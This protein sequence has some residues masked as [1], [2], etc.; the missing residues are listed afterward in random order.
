MQYA[1]PGVMEYEVAAKIEEIALAANGRLSYPTILT[2]NGQ[3][4]HNHYH[5][6][7]IEEGQMILM[8]AGGENNMHYAG[9]LTR[10]FPVDKTFTSK[11]K[12]VYNIVLDALD[13][14]VSF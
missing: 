4:L 10:T 13:Y 1:K 2:I 5:G 8:D 7:K 9:D 14:A 6:N 11:E 12:G 3:T